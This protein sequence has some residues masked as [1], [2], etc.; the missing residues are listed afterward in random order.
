MRVAD[1]K[2]HI[3]ND[4]C[5]FRMDVVYGIP[6]YRRDIYDESPRL[7][8]PMDYHI[9]NDECVFRI[10]KQHFADAYCVCVLQFVWFD[11]EGCRYN[12]EC[13]PYTHRQIGSYIRVY[14]HR[15]PIYTSI[16]RLWAP[17]HSSTT[18]LLYTR[19]YTSISHIHIDKL[20][21]GSFPFIDK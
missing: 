18:R 9:W 11:C 15:Y 6:Y 5:V 7:Y 17:S 3:W 20:A 1:A 21:L 19:V 12:R 14:I 4:S 13:I 16:N 8:L 10:C 2:H